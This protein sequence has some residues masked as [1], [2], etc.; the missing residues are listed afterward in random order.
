[1]RLHENWKTEVVRNI[2]DEVLS[3]YGVYGTLD[4]TTAFGLVFKSSFLPSLSFLSDNT[5]EMH[6]QFQQLRPF[7]AQSNILCSPQFVAPTALS[8]PK[9]ANA[10]TSLSPSPAKTHNSTPRIRAGS[11]DEL[12]PN[13]L[14]RKIDPK[15]RGGFSLGVDLGMSRTGIALSKGFSVRPLTV[16]FPQIHASSLSL[17]PFIKLNNG[18]FRIILGVGIARTKAWAWASQYRTTGGTNLF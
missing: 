7:R 18:I 9:L 6:F 14:R 16:I 17:P 1:M 5:V 15:W 11:L 13:A 8:F 10:P 3:V 4:E 2:V 12:P